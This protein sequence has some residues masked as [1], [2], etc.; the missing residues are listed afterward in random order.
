[1]KSELIV[2]TF[3]RRNEAKTV[4]KAIR[5][6]RKSPILCLDSVVM[7]IKDPK[8]QITLR[9]S[10]ESAT[11]QE[12]RDTQI[13]LTLADLILCAPAK[14]A[15]DAITDR[16]M[17]SQFLREIA[18]IMEDESSALLFLNRQNSIHD[19]DEMRST[20]TLF[21]GRIHQTSLS[22]EVEVYLST[23]S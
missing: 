10:Q 5:A 11:A 9:P 12:N 7:A 2:M 8:G 22:P 1:M 23:R 16:G 17:D 20:L 6:M 18:S 14:D 19:A 13:L 4:L 21:K 15:I 3:R